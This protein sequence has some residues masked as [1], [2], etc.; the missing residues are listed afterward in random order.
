MLERAIGVSKFTDD[1]REWM[2]DPE[3][4]QNFEIMTNE[5][6]EKLY[7]CPHSPEHKTHLHQSA[8]TDD[9]EYDVYDCY[10]PCYSLEQNGL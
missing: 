9:V 4:A 10:I 6:K 5:V 3:F 8:F 1:L 2:K 7:T